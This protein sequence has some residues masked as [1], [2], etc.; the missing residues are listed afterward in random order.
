MFTAE[1]SMRSL[2]LMDG[3]GRQTS[4]RK[5]NTTTLTS[6][7]RR[8]RTILRSTQN[9]RARSSAKLDQRP[10]PRD[11]FPWCNPR[12]RC[13]RSATEVIVR[14]CAPVPRAKHRCLGNR[15]WRA[16]GRCESQKVRVRTESTLRHH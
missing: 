5:T 16:Y 8:H 9:R 4:A 2:W 13:T 3:L 14:R 10:I 12:A 11:P 7:C 1:L 15:Q 6:D